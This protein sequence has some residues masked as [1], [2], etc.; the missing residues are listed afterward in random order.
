MGSWTW[1][2]RYALVLLAAVLL[3]A[4]LS[5]LA[6]FKQTLLA[7]SKLSAAG[8]ARFTGYAAALAILVLLG[9]RAASQLQASGAALAHS[10]HLVLP[11]TLLIVASASYD[12]VLDALRPFLG[13][14]QRAAFNWAFVLAISACAVWLVVQLNRHAEGLLDA[15]RGLRARRAAATCAACGAA[16]RAEAKFCAACGAQ[17]D[18]AAQSG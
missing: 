13:P 7:S 17:S 11:I 3:G 12:V 18:S 14:G 16:V 2:G 15:L 9:R 8:L 4:G 5:E 1:I 6:V 10:G